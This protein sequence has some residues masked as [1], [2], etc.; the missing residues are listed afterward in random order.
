MENKNVSNDNIKKIK[1]EETDAEKN[2]EQNNISTAEINQKICAEEKKYS[3]P[4]EKQEEKNKS[5]NID[6]LK[7]QLE[8]KTKELEEKQEQLLRVMAEADNF[9]KR[10]EKEK[11]DFCKFANEKLL[12]EILSVIDN[13]ER[14]ISASESSKDFEG[15]VKGLKMILDQMHKILSQEGVEKIDAAGKKFDPTVHEALME[16]PTEEVEEGTVVEEIQ[17]GYLLK[18]RLLR[19]AKVTVAKKSKS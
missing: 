5:E 3:V 4:E 16:H 15:L 11:A 10:L 12:L 17:K 19:P 8:E 18:G 2:N 6:E 1:I 14:A 13:L 7:K 9:K